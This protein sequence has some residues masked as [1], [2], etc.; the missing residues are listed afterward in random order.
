M[1]VGKIKLNCHYIKMTKKMYDNLQEKYKNNLFQIL[2]I[3]KASY[4]F[5]FNSSIRKNNTLGCAIVW[6]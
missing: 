3:H 6:K 4:N 1:F 5:D 2:N